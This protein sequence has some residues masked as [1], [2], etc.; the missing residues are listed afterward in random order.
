MT[1][2]YQKNRIKRNIQKVKKIIT[3]NESYIAYYKKGIAEDN[4]T[5]TTHQSLADNEVFLK[6]MQDELVKLEAELAEL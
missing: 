6:S 2:E 1:C 4:I 5:S 3:R